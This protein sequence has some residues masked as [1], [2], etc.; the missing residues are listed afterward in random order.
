MKALKNFFSGF[1]PLLTLLILVAAG[2]TDPITVGSDLLADDRATVDFTDELPIST[3]TVVNDSVRIYDASANARAGRYLFGTV[4]DDLF[5]STKRDIAVS[6]RLALD[7]LG[8]TAVPAFARNDSFQLDSIVLILPYDTSTTYGNEVYGSSMD[9]ELYELDGPLS[10]DD[11][12]NSDDEIPQLPTLLTSGS[13][14]VSEG[15]RLISDTLVDPDSIAIHHVRIPIPMS[16]QDRFAQADST[17]F[18]SDS[19]F[20][21]D[22]LSGLVLRSTSPGTGFVGFN[23]SNSEATLIAYFTRI[24]GS[25]SNFY[26]FDIDYALANYTFNREG[27]LA[28]ELLLPGNDSVI[29]LVEGAGGLLTRIEIE[30]VESL[31]GQIINQAELQFYLD[32]STGVDYENFPAA[33]LVA[34]YFRDADGRLDVIEDIDALGTGTSTANRQFFIG[35]D[36][37][38][39]DDGRF[40]YTTNL[41]VHLQ[42]IVDGEY[43]PFVFIRVVP[44]DTNPERFILGGPKNPERPVTL[45]VAF[46]EF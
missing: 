21:A 1:A 13:F 45:K 20:V 38:T 3:S 11:D 25:S 23:P 46:T 36:L 31:A 40:F 34:L 18:E 26:S 42:G 5:G 29:S 2:C 17:D 28:E 4:E 6:L 43:E 33:P 12:F 15:V 27:S 32:E 10:D 9:Y 39:D 30:N 14:S 7:G 22:V 19:I 35:G 41:S 24:D 16:I 8:S 37:E 44:D